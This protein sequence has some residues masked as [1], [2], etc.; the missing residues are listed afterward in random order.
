[1]ALSCA[2]LRAAGPVTVS[3]AEA[4]A[5]SYPGFYSDLGRLRGNA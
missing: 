5:I 4:V 3:G 2:A 1:M